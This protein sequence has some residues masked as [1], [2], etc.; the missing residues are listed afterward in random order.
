MAEMTQFR[1]EI[2]ASERANISSIGEISNALEN[3]LSQEREKAEQERNKLAAEVVSLISTVLEGQHMRWTN[4]VENARQDLS[5][6][7]NRVQGGYRMFGKG[8]DGW[9]DRESTFS[10]KLLGNKDEVKKSIVDASKV[11][12]LVSSANLRLLIKAV[13]PFKKAHGGFTHRQSS[14][15]TVR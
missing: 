9:A 4:A 10:K 13:L 14:L 12:R 2:S 11:L 7:Q 3:A 8:L 5:A 6:S 15:S 1:Q